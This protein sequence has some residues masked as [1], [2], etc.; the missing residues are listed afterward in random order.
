MLLPILCYLD[1][2]WHEGLRT[3]TQYLYIVAFLW[4]EKT[5]SLREYFF[6]KWPLIS[7]V[8]IFSSSDQLLAVA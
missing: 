1:P 6:M 3:S 4:N 8:Y 5:I 2:S 7:N